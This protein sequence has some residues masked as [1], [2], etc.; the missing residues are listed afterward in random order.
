M[1]FEEGMPRT[2]AERYA[3]RLKMHM[4]SNA[5]YHRAHW[6]L[7]NCLVHP[8]LGIAPGLATTELHQVSSN[9]LNMFDSAYRMRKQK[10]PVIP[11]GKR[12][13][14]VLHNVFA[15]I[16]I[17]VM[18]CSATFAVHDWTAERMGVDGWV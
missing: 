15:H 11:N 9:L 8:A 3:Q 10:A 12:P 18:P 17:G 16:A 5:A 4:P 7:H 2:S 14:W 13:W 6:L 1:F